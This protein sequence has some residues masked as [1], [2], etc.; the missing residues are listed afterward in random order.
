MRPIIYIISS[1]RLDEIWQ[2]V[3][4]ARYTS[5]V[6]VPDWSTL[7]D[8]SLVVKR[9]RETHVL[10]NG[11]GDLLGVGSQHEVPGPFNYRRVFDR[12]LNLVKIFYRRGGIRDVTFGS[13]EPSAD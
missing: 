7:G 1:L 9:W 12:C 2:L 8:L 13:P 5:S 11:F 6:R 3:R 10:T 4:F